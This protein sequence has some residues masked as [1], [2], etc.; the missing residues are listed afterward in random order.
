MY[1]SP[2]I[3][4]LVPAEADNPKP[5]A[6]SL[7]SVRL[8]AYQETTHVSHRTLYQG[9]DRVSGFLQ[10]WGVEDLNVARCFKIM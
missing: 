4:E 5:I 10:F 2:E 9:T 6:D 7:T 8:S 1:I 3:R